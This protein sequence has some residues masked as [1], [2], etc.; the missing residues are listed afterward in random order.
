LYGIIKRDNAEARRLVLNL[1]EVFRFFLRQDR[2]FIPL[3]EELNIIRSYLAIEEARLGPRLRVEMDI[4][5]G[6]MGV[7]V[8]ALSLQPLVENAV[9]H[10]VAMQKTGGIVR[11]T[12]HVESGAEVRISVAN[13]GPFRQPE[14]GG[15]GIGLANVRRR[16]ELCYGSERDFKIE[17]SADETEVSFAVPLQ[18]PAVV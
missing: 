11:L 3:E 8:P 15:E 12:V 4:D 17:T 13:T 7:S 1:S 14:T 16:L 10:G 18:N 5:P 9:K 2:T 6:A